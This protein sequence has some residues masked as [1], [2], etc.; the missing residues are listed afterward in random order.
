MIIELVYENK[1]ESII[2]RV[3]RCSYKNFSLTGSTRSEALDNM[4]NALK[5]HVQTS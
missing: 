4:F 5:N 1:E 2:Y 3:Y